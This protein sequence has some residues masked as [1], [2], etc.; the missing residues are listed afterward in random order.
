[1]FEHKD[2]EKTDFTGLRMAWSGGAPC[3]LPVLEGFQKKGVLLRQGY[4]LSEAGPDATILSAEDG[5]TKIGSVGK[6]AFH[7]DLK[8]VDDKD[9]DVVQGDIGEIVLRG[10]T[11]TTGY[12]NN[13]DATAE[14]FKGGWFHTGDLATE[15]E[16]GYIF[17]VGRKKDMIISGGENIYPSEIEN[18]IYQYPK[19]AEVSV[20]GIPDEKWGEV[21]HAVVCS[22]RDEHITE[23]EILNFL[24]GKLA[25]YKIPK[26]VSFMDT[27]P[28]NP[29][30]KVLKKDL[31][32]EIKS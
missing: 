1:M 10:P 28:K 5:M 3:P 7:M 25:R 14:A 19:V 2:F 15:D 13:P 4:G 30:G 24:Q 11:V 20:I 27:L 29:S 17:I 31:K 16:D 23:E 9:D 18:V 32:K 6:A 21:G 22:K 8:L 26:S 12:W